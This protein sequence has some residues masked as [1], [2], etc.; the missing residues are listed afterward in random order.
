MFGSTQLGL[1][2]E[3]PLGKNLWVSSSV[4]TGLGITQSRVT[5]QGDGSGLWVGDAIRF[6]GIL[7]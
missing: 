1:D 6:T 4:S 2:M 3:T 5:V 7:L